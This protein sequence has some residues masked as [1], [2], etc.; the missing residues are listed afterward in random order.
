MAN[1]VEVVIPWRDIGCPHRSAALRF[2]LGW[3][4]EQHPDWNVQLA[5]LPA[6]EPWIKANA[7]NAAVAG[8]TA[9]LI[10][11]ADAD[12]WSEGV[13][14]AVA[15]AKIGRPWGVP[16]RQVRR[17]NPRATA[18]V[19]AGADPDRYQWQEGLAERPYPGAP[20]GGLLV[21][22]RRVLLEVPMDP[23]FVGWGG[24][25]YCLAA[26]T[27]IET[28]MGAVP[29]ESVKVGSLVATRDGWRRVL[30]S[31]CS[32][33]APELLRIEYDLDYVLCTPSHKILVNGQFVPAS[34]VQPGQLLHVNPRWAS[35]VR[36]LPGEV[37]GGADTSEATTCTADRTARD[38][39][40]ALCFIGPSTRLTLARS[41]QGSIYTT[42]TRTQGTTPCPICWPSP[43][44]ITLDAMPLTRG[45]LYGP[46]SSTPRTLD[47]TSPLATLT[48]S[49]A[50]SA[51]SGS[52]PRASGLVTAPVVA[53]SV[54]SRERGG[55]PVYDL[56]V[57]GSHE[58]VANGVLVHNSWS[59]ALTTL[60]GHPW[61]G[62]APLFH[63]W[64][65]PQERISR[66][67]GSQEN[68]ALRRR[69]LKASNHPDKM[70]AIIKEITDGH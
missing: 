9:S 34:S 53:T 56:T 4:A 20:G 12:C 48:R 55:W 54:L 31:G 36:P 35:T 6:H 66:Q 46:P 39:L 23:R 21:A 8:S 1:T 11:V 26:G 45:L 7:V 32:G 42:A 49:C 68:Q 30:R 38:G 60:H 62:D 44:A 40:Q 10:V 33:T 3:W 69:Y 17:L 51:A 64:H 57:E 22:D 24:E 47:G 67:V 65:P 52:A 70:R 2:V 15:A 13:T 28:A 37:V 14:E 43:A 58:F 61:R 19:M 59:D 27:M 5:E 63:L 41:L 29:I 25:D 50:P 18:E 16:H